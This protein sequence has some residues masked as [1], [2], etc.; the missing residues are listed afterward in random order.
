MSQGVAYARFQIRAEFVPRLHSHEEN[1]S[2]VRAAFLRHGDGFYYLWY[3]FQL[4]ID[5]RGADAHPRAIEGRVGTT[6]DD[7]AI[8]GGE[9]TE[10]AVMP[11]ARVAIEIG[12]M[13]TPA[14]GIV[15]KAE[16][17]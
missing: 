1:H 10:I 9:F 7:Y 3:C 15:E 2:Q 6:V 14:F 16:W 17:Y 13:E 5:F 11:H 4:P 8:V 12:V